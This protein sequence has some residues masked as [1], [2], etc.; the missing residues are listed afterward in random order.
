MTHFVP[1]MEKTL[2]E[3]MARLF[4]DNIWKLHSLP[5]SIIIDK[6]V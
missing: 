3:R 2:V 6:G 1:T 4:W 5:E